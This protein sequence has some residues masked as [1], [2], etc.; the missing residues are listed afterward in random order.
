[1][2]KT[3]LQRLIAGALL[4][5]SLSSAAL[6]A[7]P[8][9]SPATAPAE[10]LPWLMSLDAGYKDAAKR[11]RP[12]LV[13]Y[14]AE[15]CAPCRA[16]QKQMQRPEVQAKLAGWTLVHLDVDKQEPGTPAYEGSIPALRVMTAEGKAITSREG[17]L[18]G[19][20]LT[21]WLAESVPQAAVVDPDL[22]APG[23]P[24]AAT[25]ARLT[26]KLAGTDAVAREAV[27][28][29]LAP[30]P[31]L[32]AR[33]I[34]EAFASGNLRTRLA[35]LDLLQEWHAPV[36]GLDP[37]QPETIDANKLGALRG[38]AASVKPP[39]TGPALPDSSRMET[40][41]DDI[42]ALLRSTRPDEAGAISARLARFGA[43]LLPV[44]SQ[45]LKDSAT[46]RDRER[47]TALRYRLVATDTLPLIWPGGIERLA[48][49]D[50]QTRHAAAEE[51]TARATAADGPLLLQLFS[52]PDPLVREISL[53]GLRT[54]GGKEG[55]ATLVKLL[56]DPVP[57]VRAAVLKELAEAPGAEVTDAII[58]YTAEEK[59]TDLI[60]H[61]VRVMRA[62]K[63]A[64]AVKCLIG[65]LGHESW[66]VRA[67]A[68]DSLAD[69]SLHRDAEAFSKDEV[70][71]E[72]LKRLDDP[73]G[74]VA[75]RALAAMKPLGPG[76]SLDTMHQVVGRHPELAL[77]VVKLLANEGSEDPA[78]GKALREFCTNAIPAVRAAA[79]AAV[80]RASPKFCSE[81]VKTALKD[82]VDAVRAAAADALFEVLAKE[83]PNNGMI[84]KRA[85][86]GFG[87]GM[88]Q[89]DPVAWLDKFR[90]G[91]SQPSW[92]QECVP[93]LQAM[94]K[95]EGA[96]ARL[97]GA[98][99]LIALGHD[100]V[101]LPVVLAAVKADPAV[102]EAACGAL[103]WLPWE[104]RLPWFQALLGLHADDAFLAR[105]AEEM[106][107][108][109]DRRAA[110]PLWSLLASPG[111]AQAEGA[112]DPVYT[113]LHAVYQMDRSSDGGGSAEVK[114]AAA[115]HLQNGTDAQRTVALSLLMQLSPGDA[116]APAKEMYESPKTGEALRTDAFRVLLLSEPPGEAQLSAAAALKAGGNPALIS[117]AL[118]FLA[119]GGNQIRILRG[120]IYVSYSYPDH[121]NNYVRAGQ[122]VDLKPPEG[123]TVDVLL[124]LIKSTD[125]DQAA[126]A[127]YLL[128]LLGKKE[129][130]EP[131][132]A[133]WKSHESDRWNRDVKGLVTRGVTALNDDA[134]TPLLEEVYRAYTKDD[135][136]LRTFYWTIR[137]IQG[138]NILKLRKT[139]RDEV[140]M[141]RLK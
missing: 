33:P 9:T 93:D 117:I 26:G 122:P 59:D 84:E 80:A 31:A 108:M 112:I 125:L 133:Y 129:G 75:G 21:R 47:L 91:K 116:A 141:E 127:G 103:P 46:D 44:V 101:A 115:T 4:C 118:Q 120:S 97:A 19:E 39:A 96:A 83:L 49:P 113:A 135:Y 94:L 28:R 58:A 56:H 41:Q 92:Y 36:A 62:A 48:S 15:W 24:D 7:A 105:L 34:A 17:Y 42:A 50:A 2:N 32:A 123:I 134:Q 73:D 78:T 130:L 45:R 8:A 88:V 109:P 132:V 79:V 72:V 38:W 131:L 100:D 95:S 10:G 128:C 57:N 98:L 30:W 29:R 69:I 87:G 136:D 11:K 13:I 76:A 121:N 65:L 20:E 6:G 119:R 81:E 140:G 106:A 70:A 1:M 14:G 61:A 77:D 107:K 68:I 89:V 23:P 126:N 111:N 85:F 52:D 90:A 124:P 110:E 137:G 54:V 64:K 82:K 86:L 16:L 99:P 55:A 18:D 3:W 71:K 60:V 138:P 104:K 37:W 5:G 139:I 35:M 51:L 66:R 27:I 53:R 25:I 74:F 12:M 102:R 63:S 40:A 67:E 43:A 114:K 22:A